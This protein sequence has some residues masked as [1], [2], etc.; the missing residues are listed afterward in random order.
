MW[1]A[2]IAVPD[3]ST[4][5]ELDRK[6]ADMER[7]ALRNQSARALLFLSGILVLLGIVVISPAGRMLF[8]VIAAI[9]AG[10]S[11]LLGRGRARMFGIVVAVATLFLVAASYPAY[12]KHMNQYLDRASELA[13]AQTL[14]AARIIGTQNIEC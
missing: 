2:A 9:C 5:S 1:R 4:I 3:M 10:M 11:A 12:K 8:L 13:S 14:S 7:Q 6:M